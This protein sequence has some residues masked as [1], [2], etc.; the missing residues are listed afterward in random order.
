M[1]LLQETSR[2][3]LLNNFQ[4]LLFSGTN[5]NSDF[6]LFVFPLT[7]RPSVGVTLT[8]DL[9]SEQRNVDPSCSPV[10]SKPVIQVIQCSGLFV[11]P[12]QFESVVRLFNYR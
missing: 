5:N 9:N 3:N 2:V 12:L 7:V 11:F 4:M 1:Q 8:A 6:S 10:M